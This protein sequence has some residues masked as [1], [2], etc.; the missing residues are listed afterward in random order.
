MKHHPDVEKASDFDSGSEV[1]SKDLT[2]LPIS[3][4][5]EDADDSSSDGEAHFLT[6]ERHTGKCPPSASVADISKKDRQQ[7]NGG[8]RRLPR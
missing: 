7:L 2:M 1:L 4:G 6:T 3:D 5:R 8:D